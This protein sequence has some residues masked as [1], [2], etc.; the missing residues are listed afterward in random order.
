MKGRNKVMFKKEWLK[1]KLYCHKEGL[2]EGDFKN[3]ANFMNEEEKS[4][5]IAIS[6][7]VRDAKLLKEFIG[8][9]YGEAEYAVVEEI[10]DK[11]W[12]KNRL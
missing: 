5:E 3:F 9:L 1:Y 7:N 12:R 8:A 6:L 4:K 11:N 10:K 2:A